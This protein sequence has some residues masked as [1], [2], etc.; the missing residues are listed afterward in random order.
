MPPARL[1]AATLA[2]MQTY[3]SHAKASPC[4][5]GGD[6][7]C[8]L[9]ADQLSSPNF[10]VAVADMSIGGHCKTPTAKNTHTKPSTQNPE[11]Y[12]L[13]S[14]HRYVMKEVQDAPA[15]ASASTMAWR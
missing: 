14:T 4:Q 2:L 1:Y 13:T 5:T 3:K 8:G 7:S 10:A 11:T 9:T 6:L 12:I 15:D